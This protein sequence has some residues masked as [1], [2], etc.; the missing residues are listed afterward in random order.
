MTTKPRLLETLTQRANRI[1]LKH[2]VIEEAPIGI[3]IADVT[4]P[5]EPLVYINEGFTQLTGYTEEDILGQNCRILQ[6]EETAAEPVAQMRNA[7]ANRT[8][9]CVELRNYRKDGTEFWNQVTLAPIPDDSGVTY[10]V[11]FQQDITERKQYE[12]ELKEQRDSLE[13]LN[14]MVRHDIRNDLQLT[15]SSLELLGMHVGAEGQDHLQTAIES[16]EQAIRLTNSA[17]EI[18][19]VLLQ[20]GTTRQPIPLAEI[21]T[22]EIADLRETNSNAEIRIDGTLP[23]VAVQADEM[24]PSL[25]RNILSNAIQ[26]SDNPSPTVVVSASVSTAPEDSQLDGPSVSVRITD[27]GPGI[28]PENRDKIFEKGKKGT[29]S[30]GTG[31]G[32][33]LVKRLVEGYDGRIAVESADDELGGATFVVELLLAEEDTPTDWRS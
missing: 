22:E 17:R 12:Q 15:L 6:G 23:Q 3:S 31:I 21:L 13:S 26:H 14:A 11:G 7:I 33:Y 4:R 5:D 29:D 19:D 25:F 1:T 16:T 32:L 20:S 28:P 10:Y 9:V 18:A 2:R 24:L 30:D 8:S 27:D